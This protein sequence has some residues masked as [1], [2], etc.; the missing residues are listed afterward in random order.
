[1]HLLISVS[2]CLLLA[3]TAVAQKPHPCKSPPFMVGRVT[4][5]SPKGQLVAYERFTYDALGKRIRARVQ[6]TNHNHSF[7]VDILALFQEGVVYEISYRNQTCKKSA[8][9]APFQPI[10]IPQNATFQ[11]QVIIGSSSGP[12]QGLLV[13]NWFGDIPEQKAKYFLTFTEFGCLPITNLYNSEQ[14]GWILTSFFDLVIG[15]ED[16]E[17]F[18]PPDFCDT[19]PVDKGEEVVTDFFEVLLKKH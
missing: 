18:I 12:G 9:K 8:L 2:V 5:L 4:L 13:N 6:G 11:A 16:P 15:I 14:T 17:D 1:M 19:K 7:H 3:V 10:Q